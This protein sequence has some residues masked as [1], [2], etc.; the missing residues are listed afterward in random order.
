[1]IAEHVTAAHKVE[2]ARAA[3]KAVSECG[4]SAPY[5]DLVD[6]AWE[7]IESDFDDACIDDANNELDDAL[8]SVIV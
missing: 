2:I 8:S 4:P 1:M 5:V 3:R 6:A 7:Y